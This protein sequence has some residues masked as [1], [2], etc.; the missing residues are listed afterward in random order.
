VTLESPVYFANGAAYIV[1]LELGH[2]GQAPVGWVRLT[3]MAWPQ[4][5]RDVDA[6]TPRDAGPG[7]PGGP[8]APGG[9]AGGAA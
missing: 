9:P 5:L 4:I 8:G 6:R 7:N 1:P 2:S 3:A